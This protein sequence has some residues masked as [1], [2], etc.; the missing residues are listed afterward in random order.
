MNSIIF[1]YIFSLFVITSPNFIFK[2]PVRSYWISIAIHAVIFSCILYFTYDI[3]NRDVIESAIVNNGYEGTVNTIDDGVVNT[4]D[5]QTT[6]VVESSGTDSDEIKKNTADIEKLEDTQNQAIIDA[7]ENAVQLAQSFADNA[8]ISATNAYQAASQINTASNASHV[9]LPTSEIPIPPPAASTLV[10]PTPPASTPPASTPPVVTSE[11]TFWFKTSTGGIQLSEV[12]FYDDSGNQLSVVS[13]EKPKTNNDGTSNDINL[14]KGQGEGIEKTYDNDKN[15]KWYGGNA[16]GSVKYKVN[17]IPSSYTFTTANDN[18]KHNRTPVSWVAY[19]NTL[20]NTEDHTGKTNYTSDPNTQQNYFTLPADGTKFSLQGGSTTPYTR[21]GSYRD[22]SRRAL[23]YGPKAYGN[24][25]ESCMAACPEYKYFAL[26]A[27]NGTTGWCSCSNSLSDATQYGEKDCGDTGGPWCNSLYENNSVVD[28]AAA[29]TTPIIISGTGTLTNNI[30][31]NKIGDNYNKPINVVIR[32]FTKIS[33]WAF[34]SYTLN[35]VQVTIPN[36]VTKIGEVVQNNG[37]VG[38]FTQCS[39]LNKV[40]FEENSQLTFIG[41]ST[42]RHCKA[43]KEIT[44][45][46]TVT[47][48][49]QSAFGITGLTSITI[50]PSVST[51]MTFAVANCPDLETVTFEGSAVTS[52]NSQ[53]FQSSTNLK[54]IYATSAT[55]RNWGITPGQNNTSFILYGPTN[56]VTIAVKE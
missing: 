48:I 5:G 47:Y 22:T 3:V 8:A 32:G 11:V 14:K 31:N 2:I 7:A 12:S 17:G 1:I 55:L 51:L 23:N 25:Q 43:L 15:T 37:G 54:T 39:K 21:I 35:L 53:W 26:Q 27:G 28:G 16:L 30:V 42:F 6:V 36:T 10:T 56:G 49:G 45:P 13:A 41:V 38:P 24:T 34:A 52:V 29:T 33:G 19:Y 20:V 18:K 44:I 46:P 9:N 40:I 4:R 50:P